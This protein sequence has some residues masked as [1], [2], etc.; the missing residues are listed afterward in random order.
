ME[1]RLRCIKGLGFGGRMEDCGGEFKGVSKDIPLK[2]S[3][4]FK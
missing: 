4:F 1:E 2:L 3:P